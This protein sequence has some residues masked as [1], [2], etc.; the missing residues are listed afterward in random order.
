MTKD[1]ALKLAL[2]KM[3]YMMQHGEWYEPEKAITAIKGALAQPDAFEQGRQEGM[4]QER[5]LWELTKLGQEI[6]AQPAQEA[7]AF[8]AAE[9]RKRERRYGYFPKLHPSEYMDEP[10]QE[11]MA[12]VHAEYAKG[13]TFAE[14]RENMSPE[15]WKRGDSRLMW[16]NEGSYLVH[17]HTAAQPAQ[18]PD[19]W[20]E[21]DGEGGYYYRSYEHNEDYAIKW[22]ANNPNHKGWVQPLYTVPPQRPWVG[23]TEDE[24]YTLAAGGHAVAT[25][26]IVNSI[27]KGKNT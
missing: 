6:E 20:R 8:I 14:M 18:E 3:E 11:P 5:A 12:I 13:V 27:L 24:I 9:E 17:L 25:T 26:K 21:F 19:A 15:F 10:A 22:D 1:K 2:T 16:V 23:L 4:K 7:A